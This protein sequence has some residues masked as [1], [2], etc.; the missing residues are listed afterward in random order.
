LEKPAIELKAFAKTRELNPGESQEV[1]M[2]FTNYD[3][4]SYDES[5]QAFVTDAGTY[6]GR[7][8]ASAT[9]IRQNVT[10]KA[11]AGLVKCHDALKVQK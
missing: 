7:F 11:D 2:T 6:T 4:A 8:A 1:K 5:Q 3:L 10:F 9:D